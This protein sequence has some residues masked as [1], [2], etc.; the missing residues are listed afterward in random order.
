[1]F[2]EGEPISSSLAPT[3][4]S[5]PRVETQTDG[6]KGSVDCGSVQRSHQIKGDQ[7]G[8]ELN[9]IRF[10]VTQA[11]CDRAEQAGGQCLICWWSG[12]D[13]GARVHTGLLSWFL[14]V[15]HLHWVVFHR[16]PKCSQIF[17][18]RIFVGSRRHRE[19][20]G[21]RW[22]REVETQGQ[23]RWRH[24][25]K[26]SGDRDKGG[27]DTGTREVETDG[28]GRWRQMEKGEENLNNKDETNP[29]QSLRRLSPVK[30]STF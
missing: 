8:I 21:D 3:S 15:F 27:G 4:H 12:G 30:F 23:G 1:M 7:T 16:K 10:L 6:V 28:E 22:R 2:N 20:G 11:K 14:T 24:R 19:K 13:P 5:A 18:Q 29:S 9:L 25:K 17:T 26:G